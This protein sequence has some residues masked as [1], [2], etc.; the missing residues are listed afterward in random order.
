MNRFF[1]AVELADHYRLPQ[2]IQDQLFGEV[3]PVEK[4]DQGEPLFL[5]A[6]VDA[7]LS[8]RYSVSP[9]RSG[10][11]VHGLPTNSISADTDQSAFVTVAEAQRRYLAGKRSLRWWYRRIELNMIAHHR[12]GDSLLLRIGDIE[13]FIAES[14]TGE[15]PNEPAPP[16]PVV[17][18]SVK[19]KCCT[20]PQENDE[21]FRFF[22]R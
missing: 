7:W 18:P 2:H 10:C 14:R 5:E 12:V 11:A 9:W 21:R 19:R 6:H 22:P 15:A 17:P 20:K 4:D 13:K 16:R 1:T 8:A 3:L